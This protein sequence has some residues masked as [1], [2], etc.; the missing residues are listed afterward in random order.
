MRQNRRRRT[1]TVSHRL[2]IAGFGSAAARY[3]LAFSKL[4]AASSHD[5]YA[6]FLHNSTNQQTIDAI[7]STE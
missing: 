2:S 7:V 1:N 3:C 4:I 5:V 6:F